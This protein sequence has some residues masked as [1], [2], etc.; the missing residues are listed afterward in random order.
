MHTALALYVYEYI[1]TFGREVDLFWKRKITLAAVIFF[2]SRY[3]SLCF[4]LFGFPFQMSLQVNMQS[5][6]LVSNFV[7]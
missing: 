6:E 3:I 7:K 5:I 2:A 1:I 4:H